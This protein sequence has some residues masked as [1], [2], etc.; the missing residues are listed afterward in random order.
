MLNI[1]TYAIRQAGR[2]IIKQYEIFNKKNTS[3]DYVYHFIHNT[4]TESNYIITNIIKKFYP[5]HTIIT[6]HSNHL[7]HK[8]YKNTTCWIID[9]TSN[10][11]N[12]IKQF[13]FLALSIA[14]IFK[15]HIKIGVI[16][17]PIHNELFSA[18]HGQGAQ[19]NGYKIRVNTTK[20]LYESIL[21]IYYNNK[22]QHIVI[23]FLKNLCNQHIH[24]R[25]T[26]VIALDLAYVAVGRVDG[27]LAIS[28]QKNHK[29]I[30]GILIIKESG[31][32]ITD[33]SGSND[34]IY[35][36]NIIAGNP[37]ITKI[38]LSTM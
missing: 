14:V 13:P 3:S 25:C 2:F 4:Y 35:T 27:C 1:A 7:F 21:A 38:L 18:S 12:F 24:F 9:S 6:T 37:K 36:G 8:K 28:P 17:D 16:Y 32:L 33:F 22:Q 31:G 5:L 26:G 10:N 19:L 11:I 15:D 20:N 23:N 30:S 29:I 34:Y